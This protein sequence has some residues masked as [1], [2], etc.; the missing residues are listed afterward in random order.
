[1][2]IKTSFA[3]G[4][5]LCIMALSSPAY[6]HTRLIAPNGGEQIPVGSVYTIEWTVVISH[7]LQNWDLWY[8]TTGVNGP[9]IEIAM[10]L[11]PGD[12]S[13]GSQHTY[14]WTVP[15]TLSNQVRV[16]VRMDNN[17]TDYEDKSDADLSIISGITLHQ[18]AITRGKTT[19]FFV[20]EAQPGETVHFLYSLKGVGAGPIVAPLGGLQLDLLNPIV[21]FGTA[22]ADVNGLALLLVDI[23]KNLPGINLVWTQAVIRR[24]SEGSS[25]IK[26]NWIEAPVN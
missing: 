14:Q 15:D 16:R 25:S 22:R 26:T 1:M 23:P 11:P 4:L 7:D 10:D 13:V 19:T 6:A 18:S 17:G 5:A 9:W 12:G 20:P 8:S 24:G 21:D 3:Y 2:K